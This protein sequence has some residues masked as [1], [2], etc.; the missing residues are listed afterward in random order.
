MHKNTTYKSVNLTDVLN[1]RDKRAERIF[2]LQKKYNSAV[3]SF[4]LNIAGDIKRTDLTFKTFETGKN[5]I[6]SVLKRNEIKILDCIYTDVF[7]G[8]EILWVVDLANMTEIETVELKKDM[9]SIEDFH[10][11]GRLFDIDVIKSGE[12]I[13]RF[14]IGRDERSC[15]ICGKIGSDCARSRAHSLDEII[16]FTNSLMENFFE[17]EFIKKITRCAVKS[18][19]YEVCVTPKPG[20][21]DRY[22]SG[23]HSDMDIFTFMDSTCAL[24]YYFKKIMLTTMKNISTKPEQLI[25]KIRE[26]GI[27]AEEEMFRATNGVNTH[28]GII[29]SMGILCAA[30]AY[31]YKKDDITTD[32]ILNMCA[33]IASP[34]PD[35]DFKNNPKSDCRRQVLQIK[36][37]GEILY[38]RYKIQG[39]RGEV[40]SGFD[41]VKK[42][43]LPILKNCINDGL[44]FN[45]AGL[46]VLLNLIANVEDTAMIN[47]SDIK[48]LKIIQ[49]DL[50]ILLEKYSND[51]K[52]L[53][54]K[55][56]DLDKKFI[57]Q[58]ISPGGCADLLA[59]TFMLYFIYNE[60]FL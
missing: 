33:R 46:I 44:S 47:R 22:N 55:A 35:S 18:L 1:A 50:K 24:I 37:N 4:T 48:T 8:S 58:N 51:S 53:I 40:A 42:Y 17:N 21:V 52:F 30:C 49:T 28:K 15:F 41:S 31:L 16:E 29:F 10:P 59:I 19:L 60:G 3:I 38:S 57:K 7:T 5:K 43:G 39:V 36:T 26:L 34:I 56:F 2:K 23:A 9:V 14:E 45:D 12:K 25:F 6:L 11:L 32:N 54:N 13:S 20:L 27:D